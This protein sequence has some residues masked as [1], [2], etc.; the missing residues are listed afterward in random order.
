[1]H[2]PQVGALKALDGVA[3][4]GSMT[5]AAHEL[6]LTPSA[7]SHALKQ[8]EHEIGFE[9]FE[10]D[11][12]H[13]RLTRAG[14]LY[15]QEVRRALE[16]IG[17]ARQVALESRLKGRFSLSCTPGLAMFW[18]VHHIDEFRSL[19]PDVAIHVSSPEQF[20]TVA[21]P[22]IDLFVAFGTGN[23]R[24]YESELLADLEFAPYCSP[25]LLNRLGGL[26]VPDDVTRFPLLHLRTFEDWT[27]WLSAASLPNL[28]AERGIVMS[29]MYLVLGAAL[30]GV[31]V[32]IGDN[33]ACRRAL[34]DGTL[35]RPFPLTI[36]STQAYYFVSTPEKRDLP[37]SRAFR[38]WMRSNLGR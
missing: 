28:D 31:G 35:V 25:A 1:M 4:H 17:D 22:D 2:I 38:D 14:R 5:K 30:E 23:W 37:V 7:I 8:L 9:L 19:F 20:E 29:N 24:G 16:I 27:R 15:A 26:S 18:L 33:I 36:R 3:R 6:H 10:R 12:R 32:A 13:L 11:G 21:D 34:A